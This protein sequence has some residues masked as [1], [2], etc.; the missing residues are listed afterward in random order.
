MEYGR[1]I[2]VKGVGKAC[3]R[4]DLIVIS[5][6]LDSVSKSYDKAMSLASDKLEEIYTSL[7]S[8]GIDRKEVKTVS[9]NV[10]TK[11]EYV[12]NK[13]GN[14]VL[15]FIGYEVEHSLKVAFDF[16]M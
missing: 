11:Y 15:I 5:L 2:V 4:P 12:K 8:I 3:S 10:R 6:D 16:D 7:E 1:N 14:S 9:F 13:N